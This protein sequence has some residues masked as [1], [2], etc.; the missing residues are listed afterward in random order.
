MSSLYQPLDEDDIR[1]LTVE[2]HTGLTAVS[3]LH[4][5][6]RSSAPDYDAVTYTW[7][8][9][10][11]MTRISCNASPLDI[12]TNLFKALPY[13]DQSRP[14]PHRPLWIDAICLNQ[15]DDVE[16][17][18]QVP[19]MGK[20]YENAARTLV[21]LGEAAD[22]SDLALDGVSDL[23]QAMLAADPEKVQYSLAHS[24]DIVKH[25]LPSANGPIW[26]ALQSLQL[27]E[28]FF[29]LWTLQEIVLSKQPIIL[30][31]TKCI[32]WESLPALQQAVLKA[33]LTTLASPATDPDSPMKDSQTFIR[34]IDGMRI[35]L[36]SIR[37][38]MN[39]PIVV[40]FSMD[41]NYT[42]R[43]DR[44]WAILGL[45][46]DRERRILQEA[47]VI[48]YS[49][50]A[51]LYYYETYLSIMKVQVKQ[52]KY[53][54]MQLLAEGLS[55]A[56]NPFLPS[57]CPDWHLK[58]TGTP[59]SR[60]LHAAAGVPGGRV[61]VTTPVKVPRPIMS[62]NEDSSLNVLGLSLDFIEKVS[63]DTGR[64]W[65]G[66]FDHNGGPDTDRLSQSYSWA[67]GCLNIVD[68]APEDATQTINVVG[69]APPTSADDAWAAFVIELFDQYTR[70]L[71]ALSAVLFPAHS[72]LDPSGGSFVLWCNSRKF[73]RTKA[74]KFGLG[75][76]D[77]EKDDVVCAL[78][79][80]YPLFVLR[81]V[82][83]EALAEQRSR[84]PSQTIPEEDF[85][86]VGDAYMP[87]LMHGE[88]FQGR[89]CE[90]MRNF[91]LV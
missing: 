85:E 74:G 40:Q 46:S 27:R 67:K 1:L 9:D 5:Y 73:F 10:R 14:L 55:Q 7:G 24:E 56:K 30:C 90:S 61:P 81:P 62:T 33:K 36:R 34:Q 19:L 25:G 15:E 8:D 48:D 11:A 18:T 41:R 20:V 70:A 64:F 22:D 89:S 79:G 86:V 50:T 12:R 82:K 57:W 32:S 16:K 23:T 29:R 49:T 17:S 84:P 26:K 37:N 52:N 68:G 31:G 21:W 65:I 76:P 78:F 88:A 6:S 72:L 35:R 51:R 53:A 4:T 69:A 13:L 44:I 47:N 39:L 71:T 75:P 43:V 45:L 83:F 77:L 54:A 58:R 66:Y 28:W 60:M 59:L 80:G 38:A 63:S 87:D 91:R 3:K 42:E 2:S